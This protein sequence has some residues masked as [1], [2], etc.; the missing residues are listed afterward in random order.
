MSIQDV[1]KLINTSDTQFIGIT[2]SGT[3]NSISSSKIEEANKQIKIGIQQRLNSISRYQTRNIK[4]I[5]ETQRLIDQLN[6]LDAIEGT[7]EFVNYVGDNII[8][9]F[10]FLNKSFD[11]ITSTQI[12]Q[13]KRDYLGFFIPM[14]RNIQKVLDTT[15]EL[16]GIEDYDNFR[17]TVDRIVNAQST[18]INKY[19]NILEEKTRNFLEE[20]ATTS[21]SATVEEMLK[22]LQDPSKDLSWMEM[23]LGQNSSAGNEVIR[24][25]A[26][27]LNQ[28]INI[29][30]RN[31]FN[32]GVS[33]VNLL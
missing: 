12:V 14:I 9:A 11:E 3:F 15:T 30:K 32:Q 18:I 26:D 6:R 27:I 33:L 25:M 22:W 4:V 1:V 10:E 28:Q 24:I 13:L 29:T 5:Q 19:D 17:D 7:V 20:Y 16:E 2:Y 21:G 23:W 8:D 31:T